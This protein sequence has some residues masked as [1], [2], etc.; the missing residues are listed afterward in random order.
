MSG[1][2][3]PGPWFAGPVCKDEWGCEYVTVGTYPIG[4][5]T[6]YEAKDTHVE[7]T[8]C[9]VWGTEN[10]AASVAELIA[11]APSM[12]DRIDLLESALKLAHTAL[13]DIAAKNKLIRELVLPKIEQALKTTD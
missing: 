9:E 12:Q 11:K 4:P 10:D 1:Y 6:D 3:P 7:D 2:I 13:V 5:G 8:I